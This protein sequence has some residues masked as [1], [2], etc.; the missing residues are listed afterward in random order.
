MNICHPQFDRITY[1][2]STSSSFI[3]TQI[4]GISSLE[5]HMRKRKSLTKLNKLPLKIAVTIFRSSCKTVR[6]LSR[7]VLHE[8]KTQNNTCCTWRGFFIFSLRLWLRYRINKSETEISCVKR[9]RVL[10]RY[11]FIAIPVE[12]LLVCSGTVLFF[13]SPLPQRFSWTVLIRQNYSRCCRY[14]RA[15]F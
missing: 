9:G 4:Y 2:N 6:K 10:L 5:E 1:S 8:N 12:L 15:K 13:Y 14:V 7:N 11:G 3:D